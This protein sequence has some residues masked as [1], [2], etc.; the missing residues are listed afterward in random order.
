[1]DTLRGE[2]GNDRL[3]GGNGDDLLEGGFGDDYLDAG[4]GN[5]S[6]FGNDGND[7]LKGGDGLDALDGG[8]GNDLLDAGRGDRGG[9][10]TLVGGAGNDTL[11]FGGGRDR[12]T[13][14]TSQAVSGIDVVNNFERG[15]NKDLIT[16]Q[17]IATIDV[18]TVGRDTQF[19]MSD[20][21]QGNAGFGTGD[22]LV[23]LQRTTGF[24]ADTIAANV[25]FDSTAQFLFG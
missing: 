21:I 18:V 1:V 24:T 17:E 11:T 2:N 7:I 3:D 19:R 16:F 4:R 22:L 20:G 23:T 15:A 12:F 14:T 10:N 25:H 8:A 13:Y 5:D 6:L 9:F